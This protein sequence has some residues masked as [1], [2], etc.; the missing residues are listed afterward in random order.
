[1][2]HQLNLTL[3]P[4]AP[5]PRAPSRDLLSSLQLM[6]SLEGEGLEG[7]GFNVCVPSTPP[8]PPSPDDNDSNSNTNDNTDAG[9]APA[10]AARGPAGAG[11]VRPSLTKRKL[12][13]LACPKR[14]LLTRTVA[15]RSA[16][17][18]VRYV[19]WL[20]RRVSEA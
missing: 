1:M 17:G 15:P 19:V 11:L 6:L 20:E 5:A 18:A 13:M 12:G 9:G 3:R 10:R 8:S 14:L 16:R 2:V 7:E 4:P